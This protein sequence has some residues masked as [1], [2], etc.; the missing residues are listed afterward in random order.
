MIGPNELPI[1]DA[2]RQVADAACKKLSL[3]E[4]SLGPEHFYASLP[5][6]VIDAVFSIRAIYK[7][8]RNTVERWAKAQ[9]PEWPL[10]LKDAQREHTV[11]DF[12]AA[13][14][15]TSPGELANGPFCNRQLTS[16]RNGILKTEAVRQFALAL[17][18]AGIN[19]ICDM[20]DKA[21]VESAGEEVRK[22]KG[23]AS[24]I[25]FDYFRLLAGDEEMVKEDTMVCRF[26]AGAIGEQSDKVRPRY[27]KQ[28]V[29]EAA[30]LL[31]PDHPH[32]TPRLLDFVIWSFESEKSKARKRGT[33]KARRAVKKCPA[34]SV[35]V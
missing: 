5:L 3:K 24:G 22:I 31:K 33:G 4:A 23:Q 30:R 26:V 14:G 2:A 9:R 7:A 15:S 16:S 10:L 19:S 13:L 18:N 20:S 1:A 27:A 34:A 11:D 35:S 12:I 25:S 21:K 6:C 32:M 8:T 17:R 28:V 29:I